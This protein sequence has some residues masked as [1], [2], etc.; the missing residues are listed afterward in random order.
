[1]ASIWPGPETPQDTPVE[2]AGWI[3]IPDPSGEDRR[4]IL[5][6][7]AP[8][9]PGCPPDAARMVEVLAAAPIAPRP[10]RIRLTGR[11][12]RLPADDPAGWR[13]QLREARYAGLAEA[14]GPWLARRALLA[15]LPLACVA[16]TTACSAPPAAAETAALLAEASPMDLHSH[17]GRVIL[18]RLRQRPFEPVAAPM[19]DGG[20]RLIALAIVADT[21]TTH[22][23]GDNRI[24]AFRRPEPGELA[25]HGEAAFAR[26]ATLVRE[27]GLAVVTDQAS[28]RALGAGPGI[29]VAA[30]GA[31]FL[32]GRLEALEAAFTAHWLRHLQL[33][34]YRVNE[35]G[36]IQT[37]PPV[38]DGLT[39]FGA[40]VVRDCNRRG[41]V[42][43]VAHA[44]FLTVKGV[45]EATARPLVLSHTSITPRPGPR[46]RQITADH[47]RL[48]AS[49]GG[50]IGIWPPT[51]IF[52]TLRAYAE[53][54]ARMVDVVGVEHVGIG[55]DMQGL[56][57]PA[58]FGDYR[59]TPELAAALLATGFSRAEAA[60]LLGGNYARVLAAVL[61][62]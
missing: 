52:P 43:D 35:L 28:L 1:M 18:A 62:G 25:A 10:G 21:L 33:V 26:L 36:D 6:P 46:S 23:T 37:E 39:P 29:V 31:D 58:A 57:S 2:I 16:A 27:Q 61:P 40:A 42:V 20:M 56:L 32:E 51:T 17:A 41:I 3:A 5:G 19:R 38:H 47:A 49:T 8:C 13:W 22:V 4:F 15:S 53:G 7:E 24:Q 50:V 59:Q 60:K 48:V 45:V 34:H 9:C 30:E 14:P 44:T 54:M 12:H 11:W 55:S